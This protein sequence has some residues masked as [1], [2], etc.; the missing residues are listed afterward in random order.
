MDKVQI[1]NWKDVESEHTPT[2]SKVTRNG[3]IA[4]V[5][6]HKGIEGNTVWT[7]TVHTQDGMCVY[8]GLDFSECNLPR[9]KWQ[10]EQIAPLVLR[11]VPFNPRD[12]RLYT[13][14][15]NLEVLVRLKAV[16]SGGYIIQEMYPK[17]VPTKQERTRTCI[18]RFIQRRC[19]A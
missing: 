9:T 11:T 6:C 14:L 4:A 8:G 3:T 12:R 16:T 18:W 19:A 1:I 2:R 15:C 13:Q 7:F 17:P 10:L 5:E